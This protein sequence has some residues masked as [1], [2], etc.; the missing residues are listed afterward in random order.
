MVSSHVTQENFAQH[1]TLVNMNIHN[2]GSLLEIYIILLSVYKQSLS[3][4]EYFGI[5]QIVIKGNATLI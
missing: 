4:K 2:I 5:D 3:M 1:L